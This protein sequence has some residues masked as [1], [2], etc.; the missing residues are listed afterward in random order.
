MKHLKKI[1]IS[2]L[3]FGL[4][5]CAVCIWLNY[6]YYK[7]VSKSNSSSSS[8]KE[9]VNSKDFPGLSQEINKIKNKRSGY[10]PEKIFSNGEFFEDVY[11]DLLK[12]AN[13][14][15]LLDVSDN[16]LEVYRFIWLRSFH[17]PIIVAIQKQSAEIKIVFKEL[18]GDDLKPGKIII[19]KEFRGSENK[20][21]EFKK[22][23]NDAN[24]WQLPTGSKSGRDGAFWVLE[25]VK[26][27]RYHVVQR[28]SPE[29]GKYRNL[30]LF[31][32]KLAGYDLDQNKDILY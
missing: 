28:W 17:H 12:T 6:N 8:S 30:G 18:N 20:W 19:E 4:G 10:F 21:C 1:L 13:E 24:Y 11:S 23:L 15:S 25:A 31:I 32:L 22:L 26:D 2:I 5:I 9:C 16:N 29:N 14:S 7:T 3:T 27:K